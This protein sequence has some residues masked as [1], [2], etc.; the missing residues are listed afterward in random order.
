MT[1]PAVRRGDQDGCINTTRIVVAAV[2]ERG[3]AAR[4]HHAGRSSATVCATATATVHRATTI[5]RARA[6]DQRWGTIVVAATDDR[7]ES[8]RHEQHQRPARSVDSV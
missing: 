5:H 8:E 3:V 4:V 7:G 1:E 6:T 2:A